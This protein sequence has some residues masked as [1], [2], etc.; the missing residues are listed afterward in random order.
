MLAAMTLGQRDDADRQRGP[1]GDV[2]GKAAEAIL[3]DAD[4]GDFRRAA[5]DIEKHDG[6]RFASDQRRA[7]GYGK[8]RF[9]LAVDDLELEAGLGHHALEEGLAICGLTAGFGRDQP[10][11]ADFAAPELAGAD[12]Q[13]LDG[14][15]H[16]LVRQTAAR[17]KPLAEAD[18]ARKGIDDAELARPGRLRDEQ[19]AIVGAEIER[20]IKFVRP[21]MLAARDRDAREPAA[22]SAHLWASPAWASACPLARAMPGTVAMPAVLATVGCGAIAG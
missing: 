19:A 9:G 13:R 10:H 8:P 3:A 20:G 12:P 4:D 7:A 17:G 5:A 6:T 18:D 21:R 2:V 11:A 16:R 1:V 14:A 15:V 22:G